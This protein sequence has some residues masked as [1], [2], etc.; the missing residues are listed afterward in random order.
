MELATHRRLILILTILVVISECLY[1]FVMLT[2]GSRQMNPVEQ[3]WLG[4]NSLLLGGLFLA[5]AYYRASPGLRR[6]RW[7]FLFVAG[8]N[9]IS[10]IVNVASALPGLF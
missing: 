5:L 1:L 4:V 2:S 10:A 8:L 6:W 9:L 3:L 7:P